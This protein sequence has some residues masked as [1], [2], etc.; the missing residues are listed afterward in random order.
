MLRNR[1]FQCDC[2][3]DPI[4]QSVMPTTLLPFTCKNLTK[5]LSS[6]ISSFSVESFPSF[7]QQV[8]HS[9]SCPAER[10]TRTSEPFHPFVIDFTTDEDDGII[11]MPNPEYARFSSR[12]RKRVFTRNDL[13]VV[14]QFVV[15]FKPKYFGWVETRKEVEVFEL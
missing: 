10:P 12:G 11:E 2:T 5:T 8:Q 13:N 4:D 3:L 7:S 6:Y 15:A 9:V 1:L 14:T